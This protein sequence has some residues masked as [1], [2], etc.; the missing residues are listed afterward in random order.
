MKTIT[1]ESIRK[2]PLIEFNGKIKVV[3]TLDQAEKVCREMETYL[4]LGFDTEKKPA[5]KRGEYYAPALV[6]LATNT[7][8]YLFQIQKIGLCDCLKVILEDES[9]IKI[10]VAIRDDL[11]D[12][13]KVRSFQPAGFVELADMAVQ[14]KVPYFGLRNLTAFFLDRRLSKRQ[15]VS[16]WENQLLTSAQKKYAATDAWIAIKIYECLKAIENKLEHE[17]E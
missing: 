2:L 10:G 16:N 17:I 6:Q 1:R 5:F 9:I 11:R 15:Q 4:E 7:T 14:K 3:N 13:N 12:L 8:A